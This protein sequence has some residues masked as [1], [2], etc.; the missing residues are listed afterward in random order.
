MH[1][2]WLWLVVGLIG[3]DEIGWM[4]WNRSIAKRIKIIAI[5]KLE[6]DCSVSCAL[7]CTTTAES[8]GNE[9]T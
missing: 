2:G 7:E 1:Q 4:W 3:G 9:G 5:P 6:F 8:D